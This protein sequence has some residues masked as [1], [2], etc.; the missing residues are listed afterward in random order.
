MTVSDI[1][2]YYNR[3]LRKLKTGIQ[4]WPVTIWDLFTKTSDLQPVLFYQ[5]IVQSEGDHV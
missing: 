1:I 3:K 4:E 2:I 5:I